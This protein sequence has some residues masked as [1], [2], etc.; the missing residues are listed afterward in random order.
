M[1]VTAANSY[2]VTHKTYEL[3]EEEIC[4]GFEPLRPAGT[5]KFI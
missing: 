2:G 4:S 1:R 5:V 3:I